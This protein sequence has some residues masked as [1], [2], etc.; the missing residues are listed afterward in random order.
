MNQYGFKY[1]KRK[2]LQHG[3]WLIVSLAGL[4]L[5]MKSNWLGI[6][7]RRSQSM[8]FFKKREERYPNRSGLIKNRVD[9]V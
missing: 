9:H 2:S 1:W 5:K 7:G 8:P 4:L 6:N 3:H